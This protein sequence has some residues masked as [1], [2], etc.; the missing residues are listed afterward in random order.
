MSE[1]AELTLSNSPFFGR[2]FEAVPTAE[3]SLEDIHYVQT[4][5]DAIE[6]VAFVWASECLLAE[7]EAAID[8]DPSLADWERLVEFDDRALYRIESPERST[9]EQPLVFPLTREHD[10]TVFETRRNVDGLHLRVRSPDR[11]AFRAFWSA[12]EERGATVDVRRIATETAPDATHWGLTDRQWEALTLAYERGY[13]ATPKEASLE[14]VADE[15]G[16]ARQT[17]SRHVRDA[18]ECL[19]EQAVDSPSATQIEAETS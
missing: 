6:Y 5:D 9:A 15:L 4:G 18:V 11:A 17:L 7:F 2:T 3:L 16:V 13:F 10:V 8:D 19:V 12:L 14:D 1:I